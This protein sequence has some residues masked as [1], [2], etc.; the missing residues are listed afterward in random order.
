MSFFSK[1]SDSLL[2]TSEVQSSGYDISVDCLAIVETSTSQYLICKKDFVIGRQT[3]HSPAD[4]SFSE[5]LISR[6]HLEFSCSSTNFVDLAPSSSD[7]WLL[8]CNGKNGVLVDNVQFAK[9]TVD[10]VLPAE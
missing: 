8:K 6:I 5:T 2:H 10:A 3:G 7:V 1:P 9:G 4:I